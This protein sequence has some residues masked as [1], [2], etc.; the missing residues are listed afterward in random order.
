MADFTKAIELNPHQANAYHNRGWIKNAKG[1]LDGAFADYSKAI[2][3]N[4]QN[5]KAFHG[6][7]NLN[8]NLRHF[9][10]ALDDFRKECELVTALDYCH[11]RLWLSRTRLGER[12][13]ATRELRAY[14]ESCPT[15]ACDDWV[16]NIARFLSGQLAETDFLEMAENSA[17]KQHQWRTC[18]ACFLAGTKRFMDGDKSTATEFFEKCLAV[19]NKDFGAYQSAAAELKFINAAIF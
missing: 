6:R 15:E 10:A 2:E 13:A 4:P 14:L 8:Y 17:T 11:C 3:L 1:D 7:G 5:A 12:E 9:A 18:E 16:S 19:G